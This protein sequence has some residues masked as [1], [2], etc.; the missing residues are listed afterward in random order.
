MTEKVYHLQFSAEEI[1]ALLQ[2]IN[3]MSPGS[4]SEGHSI[5][6]TASN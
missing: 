2:K 4:S 6:V 5:W 1:D 3:N